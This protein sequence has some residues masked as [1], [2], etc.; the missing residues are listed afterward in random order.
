MATLWDVTQISW[1]KNMSVCLFVCLFILFYC[2]KIFFL[3]DIFLWKLVITLSG[4]DE[5]VISVK[6]LQ[7]CFLLKCWP[8]LG[9]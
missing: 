5:D 2:F 7:P 6:G 8:V 9:H 4:H 3:V 1:N